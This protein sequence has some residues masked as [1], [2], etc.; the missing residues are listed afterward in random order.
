MTRMSARCRGPVE[1][2]ASGTRD[3]YSERTKD[4]AGH[5]MSDDSMDEDG[6]RAL[7]PTLFLQ[8]TRPGHEPANREL[9]AVID[10]IEADQADLTTD[11][12]RDNFLLTDNPAVAWLRDCINKTVADYFRQ[13]GMTY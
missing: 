2:H 12:L 5:G 7:W 9:L 8:Q 1:F 6:L 11:Y 3:W 10:R 4:T 13:I